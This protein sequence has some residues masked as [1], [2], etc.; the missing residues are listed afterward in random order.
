MTMDALPLDIAANSQ[1]AANPVIH[2]MWIGTTLS[3]LELLTI[4]SF[5]RHGHE[6]H[7]W[8]YDEITTPLPPG[9]IVRDASAVMERAL[10]F[11]KRAADPETGIGAGSLSGVSSDLFRYRVL[12][13]HGGIWAD[14]DVTCL[15]SF[16]FTE[17]YLFRAH[18]VGVVGSIMKAPRGSEAMARAFE[19]TEA[20]ANEDTPWLE[21][22][23]ILTQVVEEYDLTRYVRDDIANPDH[24]TQYIRPLTERYQ[25][26]PESWFAIHWMNEFFRTLKVDNGKYKGQQ[27]VGYAPDKEAPRH[28]SVM[29]ELYRAY[30]LADPFEPFDAPPKPHAS[31]VTI[32]PPPRRLNMLIASLT[33]GGAERIVVETAQVL[34]AAGVTVTLYVLH[35]V[36]LDYKLPKQAN[37][38]LRMLHGSREEKLRSVA[39]EL[40]QAGQHVVQTHLIE[41]EDLQ[42]LW[43]LGL[44]TIPVVHN[45]RP[46]WKDAATAYNHPNVPLVVAVAEMVAAQLVESGLLKPVVTIRHEIQRAIDPAQ[47]P[48]WRKTCRRRHDIKDDVLLLGMVGQ[49]KLQKAYIRAVEVLARLRQYGPAKL[50][51]I[52]SWD[53]DYGSGRTAYEAVMRRAVELGVVADVI[54]PGN[55]DPV[56][57]YYAA[58]DVFLN[59]SLYEGLSISLLE[60]LAHGCPVVAADAGGNREIVPPEAILVEDG[61]DIEAFVDA[62]LTV[63]RRP[64][65][66]VATRPHDPDLIPQLWTM[67]AR[68]LRGDVASALFLIQDL[69]IGGPGRS[70]KNLLSGARPD[71]KW[72]VGC[73]GNVQDTFAAPLTAQQ[74]PLLIAPDA[75]SL[76]AKAQAV[77]HWLHQYRLG[78][79]VIWS[80]CPEL[81]LLLA[82]CL[83]HSQIRIID[84]SPGPMLFDELE[85]VSGFGQRIAFGAAQYFARLDHFVSLYE[86]GR[87]NPALYK[88]E[89]TSV[90]PLGVPT[91]PAFVPLPAPEWLL[92]SGFDPKLALGA[93]CRIVPDKKL[94]F[95]IEMMDLIAPRMPGVSLTIVGGPDAQ[96]SGYFLELL[97]ACADRPYI[98]FV[99]P[100]EDVTPFLGQFQLFVM[101]SARQGCPNA[102]LEAMAMGLP[103][104][105]NDSGGTAEQVIQSVTGYLVDTPTEMA[106]RV[107]ELL[108]NPA[109]RRRMG[110]AAQSHARTSF[111]MVAMNYEYDRLI[112]GSQSV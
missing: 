22:L 88:P 68:E 76:A 82:K 67:L 23:R 11:R 40:N 105:A 20:I 47:L 17:P 90:I 5:L 2:G 55:L 4:A 64:V 53:H 78:A 99:G 50:L 91:P 101:V 112:A 92:P 75:R 18:R 69:E 100:Q 84:V 56:E 57:P 95:L 31:P 72:L 59:T 80:L 73:V 38:I 15:R 110:A 39:L 14:M 96:S 97:E 98:R 79:L 87:L 107:R 104:V 21:P 12:Y 49:F 83:E 19:L 7:L 102:S 58:F 77:L 27:L 16:D 26:L 70:L 103:V 6:F 30:G 3:R 85:A 29:H 65:R 60:A 94:E 28:G 111:S 61:N 66:Q 36:H 62:C 48:G 109:K 25:A 71:R 32:A 13:E 37:L 24:W 74:I 34:A 63:A 51:I 106:R 52:G 89:K 46:G 86:N 43:A 93:C 9:T 45:A 1:T 44:Q 42:F 35:E 33:R 10:L 8:A 54:A 108:R 81:K 41:A